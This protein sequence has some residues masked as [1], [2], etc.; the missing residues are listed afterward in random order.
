M[1][2]IAENFPLIVANAAKAFEGVDSMH[3]LNGAEGVTQALT[4][5]IG[6]GLAG[7]DVVRSMLDRPAPAVPPAPRA[8]AQN[9]GAAVER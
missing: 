6:Q 2:Q 1:Q 7:L 9:N 3:V 5:V 8:Q 4:S